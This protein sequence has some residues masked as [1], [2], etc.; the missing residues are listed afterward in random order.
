MNNF[1]VSARKACK[2]LL[3][4]RS[5][6]DYKENPRDDR[7]ERLRIVEIAQARPR[8]GQNRIWAILRRE[9]WNINHKKVERLY[10]EEKLWVRTKKVRRR[11]HATVLRVEPEKARSVNHI[12]TMD[13]VHDQ[14]D[15]G[16]KIRMLT[17]IDK[18]SREALDID[19]RYRQNSE[20]VVD[21]MEK[22][23]GQRGIPEIICVDNGSEFI[24]VRLE[25][26]AY[27]NGVRIFFIPPGKPTDNGHIESFN[28]KLRDEC[29]NMNV[30]LSLGHAQDQIEKW[31]VDYNEWR[32][33][34]SLGNLTPRQFAKNRVKYNKGNLLL[35]S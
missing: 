27:M 28:G 10:K 21:V 7:A 6:F 34:R 11:K 31:R 9:G 35:L 26:W 14:L 15:D 19:V 5:S 3:L 1:K 2:V 23:K 29:L 17:V 32:P 18:F 20:T 12:W 25:K 16:R 30:F 33:H 24:S 8:Y 4:S 13:F 22:L